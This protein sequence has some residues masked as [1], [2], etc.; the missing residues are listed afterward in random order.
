M[1]LR[2]WSWV[3]GGV[4]RAQATE[5]AISYRA[6][7]RWPHHLT[8]PKAPTAIDEAFTNSPVHSKHSGI[9]LIGLSRR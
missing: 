9:G 5:R 7:F 6:S 8:P 1:N 2:R 3:F 4:A